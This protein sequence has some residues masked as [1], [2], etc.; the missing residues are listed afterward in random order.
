MQD[1]DDDTPDKTFATYVATDH[2]RQ[3]Y[4]RDPAF[5]ERLTAADIQSF[6]SL[7]AWAKERYPDHYST[8]WR[9]TINKPYS[10]EAMQK[11]WSGFL[12]W[13]EAKD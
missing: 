3:K 6:N 5:Y 12:A 8:D 4:D 2:C 13:K 1:T 7:K 9:K 10:R 11:L